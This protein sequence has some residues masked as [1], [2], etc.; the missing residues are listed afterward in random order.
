MVHGSAF[1]RRLT[2]EDATS[3][4]ALRLHALATEPAAFAA[5]HEEESLLPPARFA[6]RLR[7]N[8]VFAAEDAGGLLGAVA[9]YAEASPK[10]RHLGHLWGMY[11]RPEGRGMGLGRRLLAAAVDDARGRVERLSLGVAIGNEAALRLYR[12]AGFVVFGTEPAAL[13][14]DGMDLDEH[15]M[16]LDLRGG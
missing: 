16:T 9:W 8:V 5:D 2:E 12:A 3:F 11:L 14:V 7:N 4:R 10:R 6:E 1:V 15:L 13:R